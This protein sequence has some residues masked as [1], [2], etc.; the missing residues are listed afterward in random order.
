MTGCTDPGSFKEEQPDDSHPFFPT[1]KSVV[2]AVRAPQPNYDWIRCSC[3]TS[4]QRTGDCAAGRQLLFR[5][6]YLSSPC[7][8]WRTL[9]ARTRDLEG[10]RTARTVCGGRW[11]RIAASDSTSSG[12]Y[13]L[14]AK[15]AFVLE[16]LTRMALFITIILYNRTKPSSEWE[17]EICFSKEP[18]KT[19]LFIMIANKFH[20]DQITIAIY[21][22]YIL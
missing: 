17:A 15:I 10:G 20:N 6:W 21:D 4:G 14:P 16:N 3:V 9:A 7:L 22:S 2:C 1:S 12:L 18:W 19:P 8:D 11:G 5:C 13:P